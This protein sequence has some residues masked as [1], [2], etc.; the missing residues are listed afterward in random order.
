MMNDGIAAKRATKYWILEAL[1]LVCLFVAGIAMRIC[2]MPQEPEGLGMFYEAAA[3]SDKPVPYSIG[4]GIQQIYLYMLRGLFTIFGNIWQVGSIAQRVLFDVGALVFYFAIRKVNGRVGSLGIMGC[5]LCL[6]WFLP[7]TYV[8]G[9]QMLYFLLFGVGLYYTNSFVMDCRKK[10]EMGLLLVLQSLITGLYA[11]VLV[12]LDLFSVV[13]VLPVI[14]LPFLA[15]EGAGV[16]KSILVSFVWILAA[17]MSVLACGFGE[18]YLAGAELPDVMLQWLNN[19]YHQLFWDHR[20]VSFVSLETLLCDRHIWLS[21]I[22]AAVYLSVFVYFVIYMLFKR[23]TRAVR[24]L[25]VE[26]LLENHAEDVAEHIS[27]PQQVVEAVQAEEPVVIEEPREKAPEPVQVL[28]E[29]CEAKL[30]AEEK[31]R[32]TESVKETTKEETPE[33]KKPAVTLIENPLPLPK[34]HVRKTLGYAFEPDFEDMDYDKN[35]SEKDDYDIK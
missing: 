30:K 16:A 17:A 7:I 27:E 12:Y 25:D 6:P 28:A 21:I 29:E 18:S 20:Q 10:D 22:M 19:S 26:G 34:K 5:V 14:F 1:L 24:K 32:V 35:V 11:G 9:P 3:V 4:M 23:T 31:K 2:L 8:Y 13:L 15:R 33:E